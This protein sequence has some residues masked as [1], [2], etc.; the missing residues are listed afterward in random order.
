MFRITRSPNNAFVRIYTGF[1][2]SWFNAFTSHVEEK[3]RKK[4]NTRTTILL[5]AQ[6]QRVTELSTFI[7]DPEK[8]GK[9]NIIKKSELFHPVPVYIRILSIT[10]SINRNPSFH[11]CEYD[12][13]TF[14]RSNV[15]FLFDD[16]FEFNW[17]FKF[18]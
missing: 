7:L 1:A 8:K 3:G 2:F 15:E 10:L 9:K 14:I 11:F 6:W 5:H 13:I 4:I 18:F 12:F 17:I 16:S